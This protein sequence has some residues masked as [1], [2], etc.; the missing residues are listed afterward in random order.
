MDSNSIVINA[1]TT[2]G[3]KSPLSTSLPL[4]YVTA[5]VNEVIFLPTTAFDNFVNQF[6][7]ATV[8]ESD[9]S[10]RYRCRRPVHRR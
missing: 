2:F 1:D 10:I 7:F 8:A 9:W 5:G 3:T 4:L 6:R